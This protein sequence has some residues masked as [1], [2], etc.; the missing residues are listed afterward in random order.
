MRRLLYILILATLAACS[1]KRQAEVKVCDLR[2]EHLENPTEIAE[3]APRLGWRLES[4][5]NDVRQEAYHIIV[6]LSRAKA[7]NLEG[8]LWDASIESPESQWITYEGAPLKS[9]TRCYWRVNVTTNCGET[10]WSDIATWN[11]GLLNESDWKGQWIGMDH[12]NAWDV[13]EE[14]SK[15]SA[16]YLRNEFNLSD[17]IESATLYICGLGLYEAYINGARV[18]TQELA[19]APT[20]YRRTALYNAYDVTTMLQAGERNAIG[21]TISNGRFYTMQQHKKPYKITNFG[22][23]RL[24]ACIIVRYANGKRQTFSTN[25]KWKINADGPVRSANEYDGEIYDARKELGSWTEVGYDD[26]KWEVAERVDAPYGTLRPQ[27]MQGMAVVDTIKPINIERR[28]N[29]YIVDF[30]ENLAGRVSIA[31]KN[32]K[33]GETL[34]IRY[35]ERLTADGNI[36]TENLRHALSEDLYTYS[37]KEVAGATW[38]AHFVYHGFRYVE[39]TGV[40]DLTAAD[41]V[42]HKISDRM[43][44]TGYFHSN[45]AMLNRVFENVVR[46]IQAN[47][48]GMPVDCP[49][50]DERQPWL[51]DRT[52]GTFGESYIFDNHALYTKWMRDLAEAQRED[53]CIPDVAPAFWNYYSDNVT[54]PAAYPFTLLMLAERFDDSHPLQRYYANILRWV[55]HMRDCYLRDGIMTADKYGDWCVPPEEITL[56]HSKDPDRVTE[57]ALI[58]TAYFSFICSQMAHA[59]KTYNFG[60]KEEIEL[61]D[62]LAYVTKNAFLDK[63]LTQKRGTA[64]VPGHVLYP[65]STYFGNNTVT[66]NLL[67]LQ[68]STNEYVRQEATKNIIRNIV[69]LNK[70]HISCGV[71]GVQWL[72]RTLS[73]MGYNDVAWRIA[74]QNTY[75]SWGY[76]AEQGATTIW[77]LWNGDTASPKMNSGNHVMLL[78]DLVPWIFEDIVGIR[79]VKKRHITLKPDFSV[80]EIFNID[81]SYKSIYG[82]IVSRWKKANGELTWHVEIPA[83]TTATA[84]L[85]DGSTRELTSGV[86]DIKAKLP[87]IH[88][89]V[90][91][92]EFLYDTTSF[93]QCHSASIAELPD[94]TLACTY[95][96]GTRERNPDVCIWVSLKHPGDSAWSEPILAAD[97]V[98]L[99]GT[100]DAELAGIN[101]S[102]TAATAGPIKPRLADEAFNAANVNMLR[103]KACWNPVV[104]QEPNGDLLIYFKI[105]LKVADWTGWLVRSKDGGKTWQDREPLQN[106]Y[107]GPIKNKIVENGGRLIAPSSVETSGWRCYFE[108]SDDGGKTW[109]K[110][111]YVQQPDSFKTI[112][113][114]V[115]RLKDGRLEALCRTRNRQI[116]VTYSDDNGDT[117]SE[118]KLID[119]PNNN[120]GLDAAVLHDGSF[121]LC[122]NE[123][124]VEPGKTKG[125]RTPLSLLR[126]TDGEHWQHWVTLEKSSLGQYS[127]PSVF[128]SSDGHVHAVYTWRRTRVKHVELIP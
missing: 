20:D 120:S 63:Y 48:K 84:V 113:P 37:G 61:L 85:P 6:A 62:D 110:T 44:R 111:Y 125:A 78:G 118:M 23:P 7:E 77:E 70:E 67:G 28:G 46:G 73:D 121:V 29:A 128:V 42:A 18:G 35:A 31:T 22:Y 127:Y 93:P 32:G 69:T 5:A 68:L 90:V 91:C 64:A 65:D 9:D 92:N 58:S 122:C 25:N 36:Y 57:G 53:G 40:R 56:I 60:T 117:W 83:N 38:H 34:R 103:R 41:I 43:E 75:P 114:S 27:Q 49:Q 107:L 14:H 109:R 45:D 12:A 39:I 126:S 30:G 97:G 86:R 80:D 47:Y 102:T 52:M 24:R 108:L 74:T 19:P 87:K 81:G 98:F 79:S 66:A 4:A 11:V 89:D 96:G 76:M 15:L 71:I 116:A 3:T 17:S 55:L 104:Y 51:G 106:E 88:K 100:A 82:N 1:P 13:E 119:T 112:Q 72:M 94:G 10:G 123:Q 8:D 124:P 50:R 33:A 2:T 99:L 59:A 115:I 54:W 101:D 95:F 105:G 16:R 26:S 21:V